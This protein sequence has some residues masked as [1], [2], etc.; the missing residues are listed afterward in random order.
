MTEELK[1]IIVTGTVGFVSALLLG[2][3]INRK[4]I[5]IKKS[6]LEIEEEMFGVDR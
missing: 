4:K 5:G 2:W 3:F 1:I 6:R